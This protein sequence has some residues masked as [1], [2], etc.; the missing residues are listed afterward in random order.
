[1]AHNCSTVI[2]GGRRHWDKS[3]YWDPVHAFTHY[4]NE[5][6]TKSLMD[7]WAYSLERPHYHALS[8]SVRPC[9]VQFTRLPLPVYHG[10]GGQTREGERRA[11]LAR[12]MLQHELKG[13]SRLGPP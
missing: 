13:P 10:F 6:M 3:S 7:A 1:L 2:I 5:R 11:D 4:D 12:Q 9:D 8:P